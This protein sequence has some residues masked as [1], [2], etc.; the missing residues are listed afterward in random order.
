MYAWMFVCLYVH[1]CMNTFWL[2]PKTGLP[3][4]FKPAIRP[5]PKKRS[6][7]PWRQITAE[8]LQT[9]DDPRKRTEATHT[10]GANPVTRLLGHETTARAD[11]PGA[12]ITRQTECLTGVQRMNLS[13]P[14]AQWY[15]RVFSLSE[16]IKALNFSTRQ[17]IPSIVAPEDS[18]LIKE[19][20]ST[21]TKHRSCSLPC[22]DCLQ[23]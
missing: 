15:L 2:S 8:Q 6:L 11:E 17:P 20:M 16:P 7:R 23:H 21:T 10:P 9:A 12:A 14:K 18:Q 3:R 4:S 5:L 1:T 19:Y 22:Y 13:T